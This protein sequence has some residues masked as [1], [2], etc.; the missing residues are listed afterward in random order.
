MKTIYAI[1]PNEKPCTAWL[2]FNEAQR[3]LDF[4]H[5]HG[6]STQFEVSEVVYSQ[7]ETIDRNL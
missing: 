5:I 4:N 2:Y 6:I 7:L 1:I 3:D